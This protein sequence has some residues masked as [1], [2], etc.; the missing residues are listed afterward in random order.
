[1]RNRI[2]VIRKAKGMTLSELSKRTG[3]SIAYLSDLEMNRRGAKDETLLR[4]G[5]ALE[6]LPEE[7]KNDE[8]SDGS[9]SG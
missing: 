9:A 2:R 8:V 5:A 1:M 6:V 7:L 4:I 3:K